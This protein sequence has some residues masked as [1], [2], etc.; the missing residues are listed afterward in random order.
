MVRKLC[1][2]GCVILCIFI[3]CAQYVWL[4]E[5][6]FR[7]KKPHF[8]FVKKPYHWQQGDLIDTNAI[9]LSKEKNPMPKYIAGDTLYGFHRFFSNGQV[10]ARSQALNHFPTN[11]DI[12]DFQTGVIGYYKLNGKEIQAEFYRPVA[13]YNGEYFIYFAEINGDTLLVYG[14]EKP[15]HVFGL[16]EKETFEPPEI[17]LK[18]K[19]PWM[20]FYAKPDW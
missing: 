5:G 2:L 7:P 6:G 17:L 12:N 3:C 16:T 13:N 20:Q 19:E 9:Y 4:K 14:C 11:F 8:S 10:Y 1:L 18:I 15:S